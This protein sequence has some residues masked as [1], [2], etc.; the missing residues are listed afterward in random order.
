MSDEEQA[1]LNSVLDDERKQAELEA[2]ADVAAE[3]KTDTGDTKAEAAPATVPVTEELV[4]PKEEAPA[5]KKEK[6]A[7]K[8][9]DKEP[10]FIDFT[11][12]STTAV[13]AEEVK[14]NKPSAKELKRQKRKE[15]REA[16]ESD[17]VMQEPAEVKADASQRL[18]N[19][20]CEKIMEVEDFRKMMRKMSG[21]KKEEDMLD[22][23][24]KGVRGVCV[25][26][27]QVRSLVQLLDNENNRY[28]L[29]DIAYPKTYDTENF[30]GLS[31]LLKQE[32][33]QD[34]F[35]AMIRKK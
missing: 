11:G 21:Q 28:Q 26:T 24:R 33:Y 9:A 27:D 10:E 32:Y 30:E 25:S 6:K 31:G 18:V 13:P 29:L 15:A 20:D 3:K 34:R 19:T 17:S 1:I 14:E 23:F 12:D 35:K 2:S 5:P 4:L 8:K 22:V 16:A 7:K